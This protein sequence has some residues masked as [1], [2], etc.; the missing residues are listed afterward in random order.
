[1]FRKNILSM[2]RLKTKMVVSLNIVYIIK[3]LIFFFFLIKKHYFFKN[4]L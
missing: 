2:L 4:I 3:L 1:M